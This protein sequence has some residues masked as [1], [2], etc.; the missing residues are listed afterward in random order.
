MPNSASGERCTLTSRG[1]IS[2]SPGWWRIVK[3]WKPLHYLCLCQPM[4]SCASIPARHRNNP[5]PTHVLLYDTYCCTHLVLCAY[6]ASGGRGEAWRGKNRHTG[7]AL[8]LSAIPSPDSA[9]VSRFFCCTPVVLSYAHCGF[10]GCRMFFVCRVLCCTTAVLRSAVVLLLYGVL[11]V[12]QFVGVSMGSWGGFLSYGV[13]FF[14]P[15]I[16]AP[17]WHRS[18]RHY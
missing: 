8:A 1:R 5:A 6:S 18:A 15:A 9:I 4:Y 7:P 16:P 3:K 13:F 10:V 12:D 17:R 2:R 14:S 11:V